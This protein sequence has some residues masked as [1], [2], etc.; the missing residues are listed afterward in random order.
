MDST[1]IHLHFDAP[2]LSSV[3]REYELP[4]S[5]TPEAMGGDPEPLGSRAPDADIAFTITVDGRFRYLEEGTTDTGVAFVNVDVYEQDGTIGGTDDDFICHATTDWEGDWSCTGQAVD[6]CDPVC[7]VEVYAQ[8]QAYNSNYGR[9]ANASDQMYAV[10]TA[11]LTIYSNGTYH[12]GSGWLPAGAAPAFYIEKMAMY[13]SIFNTNE[14]SESPPIFSQD[15]FLTLRWPFGTRGSSY[16]NDVVRIGPGDEWQ[17]SVILHEYGHYVMDLFADTL[18]PQYCNDPGEVTNCGHQL[19]SVE[20]EETA[21]LEGWANYFQA[22]AKLYW[23]LPDPEQ[24][25]DNNNGV[26][27][28]LETNWR[29]I[30]A[31]ADRR[32]CTVHAILWDHLDPRTMDDDQNNDGLGDAL[33]YDHQFIYNIFSY[34]D[35]DGGGSEASPHDIHDFYNA[36]ISWGNSDGLTRAIYAEQGIDYLSALPS[37]PTNVVAH[38]GE[39]QTS[40]RITWTD[41]ASTESNFYIYRWNWGTSAWVHIDTVGRNVTTYTDSG[42]TCGTGYNYTVRAFRAFDSEL[43]GWSNIGDATTTSCP[44]PAP[45]SLAATEAGT[46]QIDLSWQDNSSDE[47]HFLIDRSTDGVN[48]DQYDNVGANQTAY[49][50]TGVSCGT[51]YYYRVA[52]Y[53][54]GDGQSSNWSN[55]AS[56]ATSCASA[57]DIRINELDVGSAD[58]VEIYN[59]DTQEANLSAWRLIAYSSSGSVD[60]DYAFPTGFTIPAG[61]YVILHE[62]GGTNTSTHLYMGANIT[63]VEDGA[64]AVSLTNGSTGID[65]VRFGSSTVGPPTGTGWSGPNP[66]GPPIGFTLGRDPNGYN[67]NAG[68]DWCAQAASL[69]GQNSVCTGGAHGMDSAGAFNPLVARFFLRNDHSNGSPDYVIRYGKADSN[70][71][72]LTG[73]WDGDGD[74]TIGIYNPDVSRFMLRD[75]NSGG[76]PDYGYRYGPA[77]EGWLPVVGDWDG[78]GDAT[79]GV[80]DPTR[81]L[82]LLA[83]SHFPSSYDIRMFF[84]PSDAGWT[85]LVGDWNGDGDDTLGVY[86]PVTAEFRLRNTNSTGGYDISLF[87]GPADQGWIPIIGDWDADGI[88]SLGV[89]SPVTSQFRLRDALSTGPPDVAFRFGATDAGWMPVSGDW[90][91]E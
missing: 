11:V 35:P 37:T 91:G 84:G 41:N 70:W 58:S 56:A 18:T 45:T 43:S 79:P 3:E 80:Y 90:D 31:T 14:G 42:L 68:S 61:G 83:N 34:Y 6:P 59:A 49:S 52:A 19:C 20:T 46:D 82:F 1:S 21:Y 85:P 78:D 55:T 27:G 24:Y 4:P 88:D 75:N 60:I 33:T 30:E 63:W 47:T 10:N 23:G 40:M 17:T 9:V 7:S 48:W 72:P 66:D 38:G 26:I 29:T 74:D 89:Y 53:R 62:L 13:A 71:I 32:E 25:I 86:D 87:F 22:A 81:G 5:D 54:T 65:F 51:T 44:P 15:H 36:F 2:S 28:N 69:G 50:D 57:D 16:Q 8:A 64:G 73:D 12:Y 39:S 67:T 77:G 76:W